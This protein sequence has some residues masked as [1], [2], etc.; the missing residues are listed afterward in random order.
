MNQTLTEESLLDQALVVDQITIPC[1]SRAEATALRHRLNRQR[2]R[3][4]KALLVNGMS[5]P[6][7]GLVLTIEGADLI[8]KQRPR[9][10]AIIIGGPGPV[11]ADLGI[12][13]VP[14]ESTFLC[15]W[16]GGP[17]N[18]PFCC[19]EHEEEAMKRA[20]SRAGPVVG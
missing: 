17:A 10:R 12:A 11:V 1:E 3:Q 2:A 15:E 8:I 9:L 7:D 13:A 16:C 6:T 4:R 18:G 19:P 20:A 14:L 5:N